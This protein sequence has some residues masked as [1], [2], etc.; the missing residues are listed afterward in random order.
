MSLDGTDINHP[1]SSL[2]TEQA[3]EAC[4]GAR[5]TEA[6][7][8]GLWRAQIVLGEKVGQHTMRMELR[9]EANHQLCT[10]IFSQSASHL[11]VSPRPVQRSCFRE[12][13]AE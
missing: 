6:R 11:N 5:A 4:S 8:A 12:V 7:A 3:L 9:E 13:A 1:E 10:S 2:V